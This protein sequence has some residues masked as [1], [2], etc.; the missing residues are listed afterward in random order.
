LLERSSFYRGFGMILLFVTIFRKRW[1][2]RNDLKSRSLSIIGTNRAKVR[3]NC[4]N[5]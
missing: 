3:G 4:S 2:D 5:L 1:I